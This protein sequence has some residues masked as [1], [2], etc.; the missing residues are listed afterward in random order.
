MILLFGRIG[1][2]ILL[3]GRGWIVIEGGKNEEENIGF[4]CGVVLAMGW[5]MFQPR[6]AQTAAEG[7]TPPV[8]FQSF[9]SKE[10]RA[11]DVWKVYL[12]ASDP[13]GKM[14][15]IF[16]TVSQPGANPTP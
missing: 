13:E 10:L 7:K 9:A 8:I 3:I 15:Y 12:K 14:K 11:G 5:A 6:T 1:V 16:A 2:I 4:V